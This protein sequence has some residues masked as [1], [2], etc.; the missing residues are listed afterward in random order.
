[1]PTIDEGDVA[2]SN[3]NGSIGLTSDGLNPL[4]NDNTFTVGGVSTITLTAGKYYFKN[5][6]VSGEGQVFMDSFGGPITIYVTGD[7]SISGKG[8]TNLSEIPAKLRFYSMGAQ[9]NLSGSADLHAVV[10]GPNAYLSA[11]GLQNFF[12]SIMAYDVNISGNSKFHYD[13][14]LADDALDAG[15]GGG[16]GFLAG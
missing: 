11:S 13:E 1:M 7:I 4:S 10:L 6:T 9:I 14:A 8:V 15:G 5:F 2:T 16:G 3:S 12:G